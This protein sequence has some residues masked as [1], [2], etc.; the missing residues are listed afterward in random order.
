MPRWEDETKGRRNEVAVTAE[1]RG[2][3]S[4]FVKGS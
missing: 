4:Q 3:E 2:I 1:V